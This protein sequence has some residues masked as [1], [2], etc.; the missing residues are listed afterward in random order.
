MAVPGR[1]GAARANASTAIR[2]E[3]PDRSRECCG[4]FL[5]QVVADVRND[6]VLALAGELRDGRFPIGRR[7]DAVGLT[8][9]R[10]RRHRDNR[11][12]G[13]PTLEILVL[14][15]PGRETHA[16]PV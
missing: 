1:R 12:S 16:M 13:E 6:T 9:E 7:H 11:L 3:L 8:I 14:G 2:S 4:I 10:D 5:W 15:V